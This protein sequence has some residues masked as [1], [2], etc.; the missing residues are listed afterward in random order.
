MQV[1]RIRVDEGARLRAL[2]LK[3][4]ADA[5]TAFG[6][7]LVEAQKRTEEAWTAFAE[8]T[9]T[10]ET[11]AM[12]VAEEHGY[13][14]GMA[15]GLLHQ[16]ADTVMLGWLWV[17]PIRRRFGVGAALVDAVVKWARACD[18]RRVDLWVTE[19]NDAARSLYVRQGFVA[20]DRTKPLPSNPS[21]RQVMMVRELT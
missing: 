9:A 11:D 2:R 13:W 16:D 15:E 14:Y 6:H 18:A 19:T 8:T 7:T 1:R 4:L 20:T 3:A 10:S 21:F 5:P 17:D 12:F